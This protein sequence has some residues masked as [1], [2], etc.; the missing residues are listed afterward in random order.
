MTNST[1]LNS[2]AQKALTNTIQK[3]DGAYA[4]STIRAY[5]D[6]FGAFIKYC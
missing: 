1:K 3:M 5:K 2:Y 4:D 6:D